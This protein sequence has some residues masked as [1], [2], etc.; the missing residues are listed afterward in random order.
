MKK[1]ILVLAF[2]SPSL[3]AAEGIDLRRK[4]EVSGQ[5]VEA[6][7]N[8]DQKAFIEILNNYKPFAKLVFEPLDP[9]LSYALKKNPDYDKI[10][11]SIIPAQA[12]T[13]KKENKVEKQTAKS[14]ACCVQ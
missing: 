12:K 1:I 4:V 10:F 2:L 9:D 6:I 3:F 13:E 5:L 14:S 11:K 8:Q 7:E